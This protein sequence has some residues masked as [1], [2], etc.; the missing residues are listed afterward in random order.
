[1]SDN[2]KLLIGNQF[3]ALHG[4]LSAYSVWKLAGETWGTD[5]RNDIGSALCLLVKYREKLII[6]KN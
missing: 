2:K 4:G 6:F 5:H 1:M 3:P